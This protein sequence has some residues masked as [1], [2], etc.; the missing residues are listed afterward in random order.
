MA[1]ESFPVIYLT[2]APASG[3]S[4]FGAQ[5][6]KLIPDLRVFEYGHELNNFLARKKG[7]GGTQEMLRAESAQIISPED[8]EELDSELI[9][10]VDKER[11]DHPFLID[12]HPVTKERYGFR[13]TAFTRAQ[14]EKLR[15]TR[16]IVLYASPQL[17]ID[18]IQTDS[19]GRPQISEFESAM[20]TYL[21]ANVAI[22]YALEL[23]V[24]I[25][26][27]NSVQ[28][29][30][31]MA[32]WLQSKIKKCPIERPTPTLG[33]SMVDQPLA[34]FDLRSAFNAISDVIQ[35]RPLPIRLFDQ[36]Y[37]KA[38][39]MVTQAVF[40][41]RKFDGLRVVFIGD[42]DGIA[43][44]ALHLRAQGLINFGPEH[45]LVLDFDERIVKSVTYFADRNRFSDQ[46]EARHYNVADPLPDDVFHSRD[47]FYT[48]PPWGQFNDGESV[49]VFMERG[50]EAV[51]EKALGM[52]VIG[53]D[54]DIP[55]TQDVLRDSQ[56]LAIDYGFLVN[57]M[58]AEQHLY[59]LDDAPDLRS[60]A[61]VFRRA[62]ALNW[63][64][65]SQPLNNDRKANFYG[66]QQP[67]EYR[68]VWEV[69]DRDRG[70]APE[71]TYRL[72]R[73]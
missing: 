35:N 63:H 50:I 61:C 64:E 17:T 69:S 19:G 40:M 55:W 58:V 66:R 36:I 42:G 28:S 43:L 11:F 9:A 38:A 52:L 72:E 68:Y 22:N 18:R 71:N 2:G 56:R 30:E 48:N 26:F 49:R 15:P 59:H 67:L 24:P 33:G 25:H 31:S 47:A 12:S 23:G 60:C 4:T 3:K 7:H 62:K 54:G 1:K 14:L 27:L 16:V 70:K 13:V 6:A 51:K 65:S 21:Q 73:I 46:I 29:P 44:A 32:E 53:D 34:A 39:D 20:H 37:M 45:I 10:L 57:D 5:L 41:A 8:I